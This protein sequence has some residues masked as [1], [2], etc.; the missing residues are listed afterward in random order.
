MKHRA[1]K[2]D[3]SH[4][5]EVGS[6]SGEGKTESKRPPRTPAANHRHAL[7]NFSACHPGCPTLHGR[8]GYIAFL[9]LSKE[10]KSR[11]RFITATIMKITINAISVT[12]MRT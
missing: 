1:V 2:S 8:L 11:L 12:R 9:L 6:W 7:S 3:D 4:G 5:D 10:K